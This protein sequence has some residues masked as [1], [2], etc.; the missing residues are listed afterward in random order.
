MPSPSTSDGFLGGP[1]Q[2]VAQQAGEATVTLSRSDTAGSLRVEVAPWL[3]R[4]TGDVGMY[5]GSVDQTVTFADGQRQATLTVP[6]LAGAPNPGVV[7]IKLTFKSIDPPTTTGDFRGLDL[8][9]VASDPTLPPKVVSAEATTHEFLLSFNKPMNPVAASKVKNYVVYTQ[10]YLHT[11]T[12]FLYGLFGGWQSP[13]VISVPL[14]SAE[15]DP[16]TQ[17]VTLITKRR[18]LITRDST[19]VQLH[20][21]R[22][23]VR[24]RH[25]SNAAPGLT[26][27]QGNPINADTSPGK[28]GIRLAEVPVSGGGSL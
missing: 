13:R 28:V 1:L 15:Y 23:P 24:P 9:I 26:D 20:R 8:R 22:T 17:T 5:L 11:H 16:T 12:P 6:I 7:D 3:E 10:D 21:V 2:V 27:M 4:G 25:Q 18:N 14:R 19:V